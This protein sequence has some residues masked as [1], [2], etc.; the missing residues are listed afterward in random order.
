VISTACFRSHNSRYYKENLL[1]DQACRFLTTSRHFRRLLFLSRS[2]Y[3]CFHKLFKQQLPNSP[4]SWSH[5]LQRSTLL[6]KFRTYLQPPAPLCLRRI[7]ILCWANRD[8][9]RFP[10]IRRRYS[11]IVYFPCTKN[12]TIYGGLSFTYSDWHT[13]QLSLIIIIATKHHYDD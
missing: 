11:A 7:P 5:Y 2:S 3:N 1:Q 4:F 12:V 6:E 10:R 13:S 9:T 8:P